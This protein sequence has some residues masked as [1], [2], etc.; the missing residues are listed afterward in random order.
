MPQRT[1]DR[2]PPEPGT[3]GYLLMMK[4]LREGWSQTKAGRHFGVGQP[5][6]SKWENNLETPSPDRLPGVARWLDVPN[7][8]VTSLKY[9]LEPAAST[10]QVLADLAELASDV[11]ELKRA[12]QRTDSHLQ[13]IEDHLAGI[14]RR[15]GPPAFT[16]DAER[17]ENG[18][19]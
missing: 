6:F 8:E 17:P 18:H 16:P 1:S 7:E 3:L 19:S 11:A 12:Q 2:P 4:R 10:T 14:V 5:T 9:D 13:M 15:F